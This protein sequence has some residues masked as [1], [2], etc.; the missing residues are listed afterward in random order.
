MT[1]LLRYRLSLAVFIAGL[2]ISGMTAFPLLHE[3]SLL[4][5]WLG[6]SDPA[7]YKALS[8]IHHWIGFV[9]FGLQQ[10]YSSF[11]FVAYGTDWLAFGHLVIALFFI[12]P[13]IDP[14][15]NEWVLYCGIVACIAVIPLALICG[16][17]RQIP[18]YWS[19]IDCS[20][21]IIGILPLLYC[22]SLARNMRMHQDKL[23]Q[24]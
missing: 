20:F 22:L 4:S 19:F 2:V 10:T 23:I 3:L 21:G 14:I 18:L 9:H 1:L 24:H 17:I 12:G 16:P 15:K 5:S 13:F 7:D 11:P 8:G 6:I